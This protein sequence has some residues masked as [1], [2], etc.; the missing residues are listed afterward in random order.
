VVARVEA[1]AG[2]EVD[3]DFAGDEAGDGLEVFAGVEAGVVEGVGFVGVEGEEVP[4]LAGVDVVADDVLAGVGAGFTAV[5]VAG[6]ET[7]GVVAVG[8]AGV[9]G[10]IFSG[11]AGVVFSRTGAEANRAEYIFRMI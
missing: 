2:D 4:L 5:V 10:V 9:A 3:V 11:V 1:F 6:L 8:F 7:A